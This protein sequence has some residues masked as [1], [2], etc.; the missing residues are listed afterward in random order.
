MACGEPG[1]SEQETQV[2]ATVAKVTSLAVKGDRLTLSAPD[3]S[4]LGFVA[5]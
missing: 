5:E 1:V 4:A 3:G 2:F